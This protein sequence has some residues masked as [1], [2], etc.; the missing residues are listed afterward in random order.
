MAGIDR[1]AQLVRAL[2]GQGERV[3]PGP[4]PLTRADVATEQR[5][6]ILRVVADLIAKRGY[7][8]TS[9]DLIVRRAKV[10]YGTFYKFFADKEAAF[11]AL[12]DETFRTTSKLIAAAYVEDAGTRPWSDRLAAA[13]TV[14]Y[15]EIAADPPLWKACL[16]ESLT[17][18][19][20]VLGRYEAA[21]QQLA[22]ILDDGRKET[23]D[24]STLPDTLEG[25]LAG[26]IVWIAYQRLITGEAAEGL[27]GL[28]P[29]AIQFSLSP[30]LGE[31]AAAEIAAR[32]ADSGA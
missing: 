14:F 13:I 5:Q 1:Y 32:H 21:I 22:A 20:K 26:G 16:V 19:P 3:P 24:G 6:R 29:E 23:K 9:T 11:L 30:Y 2:P 17:A 10:G 28:L 27:P 15:R 4:R 8:D 25:T 31:T 7:A 18:G 12:F